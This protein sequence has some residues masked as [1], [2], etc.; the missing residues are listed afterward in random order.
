MIA[1]GDKNA[2][3]RIPQAQAAIAKAQLGF[4]AA[5]F[6]IIHIA[7]QHEKIGFFCFA[8]AKKPIQRFE[9]GFM[10][11]LGQMAALSGFARKPAKRGVQMQIGCVDITYNVHAWPHVEWVMNKRQTLDFFLKQDKRAQSY[12]G[13][14]FATVISAVQLLFTE[15]N[16]NIKEWS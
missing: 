2:H 14:G 16:E 4:D 13:C 5:I 3:P 7:S 11:Q 6:F 10:Q 15:K 12:T 1:V 9:G 8:Q